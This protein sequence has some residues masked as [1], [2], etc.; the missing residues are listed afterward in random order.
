MSDRD[1]A[2]IGWAEQSQKAL[3]LI[4]GAFRLFENEGDLDDISVLGQ[5]GNHV[6]DLVDFVAASVVPPTDREQLSHWNQFI[7]LSRATGME[8]TK[9]ASETFDLT[10]VGVLTRQVASEVNA[11]TSV[12]S[13]A[14]HGREIVG[15]G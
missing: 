2:I 3:N 11:L 1:E 15:E 12:L 9:T 8:I 5:A 6:I 4:T 13:T 14:Y 10:P 7:A